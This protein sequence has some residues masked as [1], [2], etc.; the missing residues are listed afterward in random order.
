[1]SEALIPSNLPSNL[2]E[3]AAN[4]GMTVQEAVAL[5]TE[6]D[7]AKRMQEVTK[8]RA[9]VAFHGRGIERLIRI[10]ES[11]D[12]KQALSALT[13]LG[14]L[15]GE[16]KAPRPVMM[17]FNELMKQATAAASAG[18][19]GGITQIREGELVEDGDDDTDDDTTE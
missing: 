19:L 2:E 17:S 1:M 16:F 9:R 8:W 15:A 18:P 13:L 10:A 12:D 11:E 3:F 5:L 14:K 7:A 6:P 4:N